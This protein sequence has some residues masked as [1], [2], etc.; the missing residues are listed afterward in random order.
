[1]WRQLQLQFGALYK[2]RAF[3]FCRCY[4]CA[5]ICCCAW[6]QCFRNL[7]ELHRRRHAALTLRRS[8]SQPVLPACRSFSLVTAVMMMLVSQRLVDVYPSKQKF[9]QCAPRWQSVKLNN[10]AILILEQNC[11]FVYMCFETPLRVTGAIRV[12]LQSTVVAV[13]CNGLRSGAFFIV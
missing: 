12:L 1:M 8:R 4:C 10:L 5:I 13:C 3:T 7:Q 6:C 9:T 2:W 11:C